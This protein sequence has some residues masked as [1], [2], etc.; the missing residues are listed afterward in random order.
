M[1]TK[2]I[3]AERTEA[4]DRLIHAWIA[5]FTLAQ[6][7]AALLLAY[8]DWL[9]H[10]TMSP[11]KQL[12]LWE[13]AVRKTV[14]FWVHALAHAGD[15]DA[16]RFVE[17]L[18]Q[19]R[20]FDDPGWRQWP[21]SWV[22]QSFLLTEQWWHY[23]TT[24]IRGVSR[25]HQDVVSFAARQVLDTLAP[26]NVP[27]LNPEVLRATAE[28]GG[29]NLVQGW[30]NFAEDLSRAVL[31]QKPAG[32]DAYRVGE[33][34][35][36][37]PG[38]VIHRNRLM[39]LIQYE[40][41]TESVYAEP[42]LIVPAWIMKFY[43]LDLSPHNSLVKY[44]VDQGYTMFLISWK[45]PGPEDRDLSMEDYRQ[46]GVMEALRVISAVVPD[47]RVHTVGYCLGG[48]LATIAAATMARDGEERLQSLTLLAAQTDFSD[49][50][51]LM[52]FID[53]SQLTFL[54]DVMWEQGC[55]DT[56][57]MAGAF[58]ILRSNDL[59]WS[60]MVREYLLGRRLE[61]NDLM[62]WNA[63]PTRMPYR[64]HKEYLRSLFLN[65]DL[66]EGRYRVGGRPVVLS[67]IRA[68]VFLVATLKDH[69]APWRSVYKFHLAA[70]TQVTFLLTS[71]GHNAG[72]ISEPGHEGRTYQ[73]ATR[74]EG[75]RYIGWEQ[76]RATTPVRQGSWWPEWVRWLAERSTGQVP[77]P[78]LGA[79]E[80]GYPPL[81]DAPGT[82]VFE[83]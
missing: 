46:L 54:E 53:E 16:P 18:P 77:P 32:A 33:N 7:P 47:R 52:L 40:P 50:G 82:Y 62:A 6:S 1:P 2:S 45:N 28:Q 42:V 58:Q 15:P 49:A 14:Q 26:S 35:G 67:D 23:A 66:A 22:S 38:K 5:R 19:D 80:K 64:M 21:F 65:N 81:G 27:F 20:R 61:M 56:K 70:D 83:P 25:H 13:N 78:P 48:T 71:G 37:T 68:P 41:R 34:I 57:Q 59:I 39:E 31:G 10:F 76:W 17:P 74:E 44:L 36:V 29:R 3:T 51:E 55:L 43:I 60:R 72:I 79:P 12:E 63:D 69:V 9:V 4:V 75:D 24:G 30:A 8:L 73:V 11:G